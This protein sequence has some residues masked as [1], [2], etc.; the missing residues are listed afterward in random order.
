[1]ESVNYI[2]VKGPAQS[3]KYTTLA[4][5]C[6]RL[7]PE[8]IRK[9]TVTATGKGVLEPFNKHAS[10]T[11]NN[12]II[13]IKK[14]NVLVVATSPTKQRTS[15]TT[16]FKAAANAGIKISLA[17][18]AVRGRERLP[19]FSTAKE[20]STFGKCL[21][22]A[23]ISRIPAISY[24]SGDEWNKRINHLISIIKLNL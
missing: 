16:I 13:S 6:H 17:V 11:N 8:S 7:N 3:G 5:V 12:F 10:I 4:E 1:M 23:K 21:H 15:I 9:L 20:V 19:D 18:I 22:E 14:R 24:K 2:F